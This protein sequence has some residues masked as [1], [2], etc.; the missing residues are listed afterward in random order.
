MRTRI[1]VTI[2]ALVLLGIGFAGGFLYQGGSGAGP[3]AAAGRTVARYTC[4]MHP[5]L[6][7]D[8][9]GQCPSCGMRLVPVYEDGRVGGPEGD[10]R[11]PPGAVAVDASRQQVVG[12]A[13]GVVEKWSGPGSVRTVGRVVPDERKVYRIAA[14]TNGWIEETYSNTVGSIVR[15]GE[16][17]ANFYAR[18]SL[19]AQ[20]SY[21]YA[22]DARDRFGSQN[23]SEA[24]MASTNL[25]V[26]AAVDTLRALG[27]SD[28]QLEELARTRQ[29]TNT[30]TVRS[31]ADAFVLVR[32]VSVGQ[33]FEAG[34]QLY[35]LA[36]ISKVW[37]LADLFESD[38]SLYQPGKSVDV[39]YDGARFKARMSDV[40]PSFDSATR[41]LKARLELDN[42]GYR[43]RP[44]MFVDVE[45][46]ADLPEGLVV[47]HDAVLDTGLRK[48]VFVDR[49]E[50]YFEPR[51]VTTGWRR[52][53]RVQILDGLKE[54]DRIVVSGTFLLD[55][56][57]RMKAAAVGASRDIAEHDLVCGMDVDPAKARAAGRVV[58]HAGREYFFCSDECARAFEKEPGKYTK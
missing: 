26:Q 24:Q 22:L 58:Q 20:Q 30:I 45:I 31:P 23:A 37:V 7:L 15:K 50:G 49:G 48:V 53:G 35:V 13:T 33:R 6:T 12:I 17:L 57:S 41:T 29:R 56:E 8:H 14:A 27:M 4:P 11:V 46:E 39:V 51:R 54:G 18:E 10:T 40:L 5:T 38:R 21:F 2:A 55:S 1:L 3:H 32:N 47:P 52:D 34:D 9:E 36:D 44:E 28:Q 25:Q 42:R 43:L 16:A 19:G